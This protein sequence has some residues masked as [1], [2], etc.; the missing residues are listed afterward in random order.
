MNIT[1][2]AVGILLLCLAFLPNHAYSRTKQAYIKL[3]G[4]LVFYDSLKDKCTS[5]LTYND[6]KIKDSFSGSVALGYNFS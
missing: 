3:A 2:R 1:Q 4:E 5:C 6:K